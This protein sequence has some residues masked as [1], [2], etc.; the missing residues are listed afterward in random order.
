SSSR[1]NSN[2]IMA[3]ATPTRS[4]NL[5]K[6]ILR[7]GLAVVVLFHGVF[8]LRNG[9]DWMAGPLGALGLPAFLGY[10]TYIAELLAP[11]L[12]IVGFYSRLGAPVIALD[13]TM[14]IVVALRGKIFT[15]N[16]AGGGWGIEL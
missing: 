15:V 14:A 3:L 8:K 7:V 11:I 12:L 16:P 2:S 5:G 1:T 10:G 9:I 6:L 13:M 4:E